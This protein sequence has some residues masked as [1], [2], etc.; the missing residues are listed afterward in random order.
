LATINQATN[1]LDEF[2]HWQP[3]YQ[4]EKPAAKTFFAGIMGYG[5]DIGHRKLAQISNQINEN[6]LGNVVRW[7]FSLQN[8]QAANDRILQFTSQLDLPRIY[9]AK[10]EKLHTSSDG[11]K[12]ETENDSLNA[13]YS[14]KYFG[15]HKGSRQ[16]LQHGWIYRF[17]KF[18]VVFSRNQLCRA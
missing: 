15:Q 2:E 1:F 14:F 10:P 5:C 7:Y 12:R 11:Q 16:R 9:Q 17:P 8:V 18:H 6:E 3:K 13:N 4:R